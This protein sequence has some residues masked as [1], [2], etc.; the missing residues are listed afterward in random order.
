MSQLA[1]DTRDAI[2]ELIR[3]MLDADT[4]PGNAVFETSLSAEIATCPLSNPC[5]GDATSGTI[6]FNTITSD[7]N[8]NAGTIAWV[9]FYDGTPSASLVI[10]ASIADDSSAEL[11]IGNLVVTGGSTVGISSLSLTVPEG[12]VT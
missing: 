3:D 9:S 7:T 10:K 11:E 6:T 8:A 4:S 1:S 12:S 2:A 5:A